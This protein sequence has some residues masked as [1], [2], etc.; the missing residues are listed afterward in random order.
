MTRVTV[1]GDCVLDVSVAPSAAVEHGG[2]V[3]A[4]IS[5][6]PGGQAANI[7]VRLARRGTAVRLVAP[8]ADDLAA[9]LLRGRMAAEG[10]EL[11]P[12]AAARS[13]AVVVLRTTDGE[14]TM[15]SD[16]EPLP[17]GWAMAL[18]QASTGADWLVCSGYALLDPAG[19]DV[20]AALGS[21]GPEVRLAIAGAAVP[22]RG[23]ERLRE[24]IAA[25]R[26]DLVALSRAEAQVLGPGLPGLVVVTD[27]GG[28]EVL[29]GA[30]VRAD[31]R[32][33]GAATRDATGAGDAFVAALLA[34][35]AAGPWPPAPDA[36]RAA[37]RAA[38]DA[39]SSTVAVTGAQ[40]RIPG[41]R[42]APDAAR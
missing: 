37:L 38:V 13:G 3:P 39:G 28:G 5:I 30:T 14:R 10:I 36:L 33:A 12:I 42:P 40:G 32:S 27:P 9:R 11:A 2:D 24:H 21:R 1:L 19:A 20:A 34:D 17:P 23:A 4:A 35:L 25:S 29:G 16:R 22:P 6:E 26:P 8:L 41:E 7:A 18:A 31:V 15:L